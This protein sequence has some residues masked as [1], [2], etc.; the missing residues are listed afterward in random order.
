MAT[1]APSILADQVGESLFKP[2][3]TTTPT[4]TSGGSSLFDSM[5]SSA[6]GVNLGARPNFDLSAP[7]TEGEFQVHTPDYSNLEQSFQGVLDS[8]G[9]FRDAVQSQHNTGR[10]ELDQQLEF[11]MGDIE[12]T[13]GRGRQELQKSRQQIMEDSF[14][15]Q[16]GLSNQMSARGLSGSGMEQMGNIQQR[17]AQG[18]SISELT[19]NY[20]EFEEE[21][22]KQI[23]QSQSNYNLS[24]QKLNDSLQNA[25]AQILSQ[26]ASARMDYTQMVDNLQRQV[27]ADANATL[28][29]QRAYDMSL[30]QYEVQK[31]Q[32]ENAMYEFS[33]QTQM[34]QAQMAQSAKQSDRAYALQL[35]QYRDQQEQQNQ[36]PGY[37]DA[38]TIMKNPDLTT[39][40][41]SLALQEM[42]YTDSQV[43]SMLQQNQ[44]GIVQDLQTRVNNL[45]ASN[46]P[47]SNIQAEI[48]QYAGYID[49]S[50]IRIPTTPTT[51]RTDANRP[52][53]L[54]TGRTN[55]VQMGVGNVD[56][57]NLVRL[58]SGQRE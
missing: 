22:G 55:A 36:A 1:R 26:E 56:Y 46:T 23:Q 15:A 6:V 35:Q 25:M 30:A 51:Q 32:F 34:Q 44:M 19:N 21:M 33:V 43:N 50:K 47:I 37:I 10:Q 53:S 54:S 13:R 14:D 45:A 7:N 31:A 42:N 8:Y 5:S 49:T 58:M 52:A 39:Q 11:L 41:K 17:M 40:E 12:Q 18:Q 57:D 9:G 29:A 16:R 48:D 4:D 28:E 24:V 2:K 3:A 20:Y 38:L 27:I